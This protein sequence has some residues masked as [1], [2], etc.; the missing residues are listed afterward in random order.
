[1]SYVINT[2]TAAADFSD[3]LVNVIYAVRVHDLD[4]VMDHVMPIVREK[5]AKIDYSRDAL[6]VTDTED[7]ADSIDYQ[8]DR[9][10]TDLLWEIERLDIGEV[11]KNRTDNNF[12][13]WQSNRAECEEYEFEAMSNH[14][15]IAGAI[16]EVV[17]MALHA[18]ASSDLCDVLEAIRD[19]KFN[20]KFV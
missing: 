7:W 20:L 17:A 19:L 16:N 5:L 14:A 4:H 18:R 8:I 3:H 2:T 11:A 6:A 13:F 10:I 15:D 12:A 9:D 1:M